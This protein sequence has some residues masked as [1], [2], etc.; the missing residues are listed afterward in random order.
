M[1]IIIFFNIVVSTFFEGFNI[2]L[3]NFFLNLFVFEVDAFLQH[4]WRHDPAIHVLH[5]RPPLFMEEGR[6]TQIGYAD[7]PVYRPD[8]PHR[9]MVRKYRRIRESVSKRL[10]FGAQAARASKRLSV[11]P[12]H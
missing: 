11:G 7:M 1:F 9:Q 8:P 2:L 4:W 5:H 3:I 6:P 12:G 10:G